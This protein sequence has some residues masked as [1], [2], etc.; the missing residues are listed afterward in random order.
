MNRILLLLLLSVAAH[1]ANMT[2]TITYTFTSAVACNATATPPVTTNCMVNFQMGTMVGTVFNSLGPA[3]TAPLP[4]N[5]QGTVTLPP[6]TFPFNGQYG[7]FQ[8]AAVVVAKDNQG[9]NITSLPFAPATALVTALP[10]QVGGL[11]VT[12]VN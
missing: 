9:N 3:A 11:G 5:M 7:V 10:G 12:A 1:A 8:F 2:A 6:V 4:A